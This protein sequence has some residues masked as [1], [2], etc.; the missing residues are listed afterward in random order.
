M[1]YM[2]PEFRNAMYCCETLDLQNFEI[3]SNLLHEIKQLFMNLRVSKD[4]A[5]ET[6]QLTS[7]FGW[8]S[9]YTNAQQ[10][11]HEFFQML[12][13]AL[14]G[15]LKNISPE[16]ED[17]ISMYYEGII[18]DRVICSIC[19]TEH[20]MENPF[21]DISLQYNQ[22][23]L[24]L[25]H[26][27]HLYE[28][29]LQAFTQFLILDGENEYFCLKCYKKCSAKQDLKFVKLPFMLTF[30]LKRFQYDV[31][32]KSIIKLNNKIIFLEV[33]NLN[34]IIDM[35]QPSKAIIM[36]TLKIWKEMNGFVLTIDILYILVCVFSISKD[37]FKISF[38]NGNT[39]EGYAYLLI[40]RRCNEVVGDTA[41]VEESS[42]DVNCQMMF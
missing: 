1:L 13:N 28:E 19:N 12:F 9:S 23:G 20:S 4:Y 30:H 29:A 27:T 8:D 14:K 16:Q 10:D 26:I 6:V 7:S 2:T 18:L 37:D 41:I 3:K 38:G 5:V 33:L 25:E 11:V 36:H 35:E 42:L 40:Y 24:R 31:N 15:E 32:S 21:M 17:F 34:S 39:E 22:M